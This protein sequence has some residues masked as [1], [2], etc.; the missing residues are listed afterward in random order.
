MTATERTPPDA[1]LSEFLR[2]LDDIS[3]GAYPAVFLGQDQVKEQLQ[4]FFKLP[5]FPH[6]LIAGEPGLGKTQLGRWIAYENRVGFEEFLCPVKPEEL[7]E[8]GVVLLD[9][10][11]KQRH[12]EWLFPIM[13]KSVTVTLL[14]ATTRPELLEPA[15]ASRFFQRIQLRRYEQ[16]DME[17]IV[18]H[19]A[20]GEIDDEAVRIFAQASAGNPRQA[21]RIMATAAG[22]GSYEPSEVLRRCRIT[23]DGIDDVQLNYLATLSKMNRPV[24]IAQLAT[25][26]YVDEQTTRDRERLLVEHDLVLLE[27]NGRALTRKGKA[28]VAKLKEAGW[29]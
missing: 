17:L 24:G 25:L 7:P 26:M 14:G 12:P 15:F 4:P 23:A 18:R 10:I 9:E 16:K 27:P 21:E 11:H 20:E 6:T 8:R 2:T 3:L 29:T 28:Y 5:Q 22:I 19:L 1:W 13:E